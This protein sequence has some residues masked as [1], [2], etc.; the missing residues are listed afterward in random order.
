MRKGREADNRAAHSSHTGPVQPR[1]VAWCALELLS[2]DP[3]L[4]GVLIDGKHRFVTLYS[5]SSW[6]NRC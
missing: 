3:M 6:E 1:M 4:P 5:D 2:L